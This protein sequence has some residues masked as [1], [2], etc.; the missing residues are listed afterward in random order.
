MIEH[1]GNFTISLK[2]LGHHV[3]TPLKGPFPILLGLAL[4]SG[5]QIDLAVLTPLAF[6]IMDS[7]I[8]RVIH[9]FEHIFLNN[10][11]NTNYIVNDEHVPSLSDR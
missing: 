9:F 2:F 6:S 4:L 3:C 11:L 1:E 7:G 5:A 10:R 8:H